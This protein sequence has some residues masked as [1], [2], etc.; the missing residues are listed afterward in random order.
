MG[1]RG[2][3]ESDMIFVTSSKIIAKKYCSREDPNESRT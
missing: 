2:T 1:V 3:D